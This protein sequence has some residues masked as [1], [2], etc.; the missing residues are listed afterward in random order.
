MT[1]PFGIPGAEIEG[2]IARW[3]RQAPDTEPP[4]LEPTDL[5]LARVGRALLGLWHAS[6]ESRDFEARQVLAVALASITG[7]FIWIADQDRDR[8]LAVANQPLEVLDRA[9]ETLLKEAHIAS[10]DRIAVD[11]EGRRALPQ[12]RRGSSGSLFGLVYRVLHRER[13]SWI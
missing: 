7:G 6:S 12:Y 1:F 10:P 5:E 3:E 13:G 9:I 11:L 4:L 2:R 8:F